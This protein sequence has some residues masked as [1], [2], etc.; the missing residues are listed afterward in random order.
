MDAL[1]EEQF[2]FLLK[3]LLLEEESSKKNQFK[4][5][6]FGVKG[7][8]SDKN[9]HTSLCFFLCFWGGLAFHT[10]MPKNK[11]SER[12]AKWWQDEPADLKNMIANQND[13]PIDQLLHHSATDKEIKSLVELV[14]VYLIIEEPTGQ[15]KFGNSKNPLIRLYLESGHF[16]LIIDD[17]PKE[18][19]EQSLELCKM[20]NIKPL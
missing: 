4:L 18:I 3:S 14:E 5:V 2:Q 11:H 17:F 12:L 15:R 1:N 19:H 13:V 16:K 8:D 9:E 10:E 7:F 20:C 6:D